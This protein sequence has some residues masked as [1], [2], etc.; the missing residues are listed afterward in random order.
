[1]Q[2]S[3]IPAKFPAVWGY[4]QTSTY[5]QAVPTLSTG[6]PGVPSLQYG[7]N[8]ETFQS[9]ATGGTGPKGEYVN[10][11]NQ[12]LSANAQWLQAGGWYSYD[13]AFSTAIGGYPK[14][15]LLKAATLPTFW[16]STVENNTT[17][18]DTGTLSAP[19]AGWQVLQPGIYPWSQITGAPSFVLNSAFTGAN[20]SLAQ[21]GYQIYPGGMIEQWG[22]HVNT[23]DDETV[24]F[25]IPFPNACLNVS[26]TLNEANPASN[27]NI[28][29]TGVVQ[30]G[31]QAHAQ[32]QERTFFWRAIG[33]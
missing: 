17:N 28:G 9:I 2:S 23:S 8:S 33:H 15:A 26:M 16:Q 25:P 13:S 32:A 21:N 11:F 30:T 1:M 22:K 5:L 14:G 18:P 12:Q 29:A 20:Q 24:T 3:A 27:T 4:A 31:F 19:A 6:T 10:G 7:Y